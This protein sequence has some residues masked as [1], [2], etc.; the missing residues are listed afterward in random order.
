MWLY[1]DEEIKEIA[2]YVGFVYKI[3]NLTN[4]RMYIGKKLAFFAR[5]KQVKGKKKRY[6]VESD[7]RDYYGSNDELLKDVETLGKDNF[8]REI[9]KFCTS[10][11]ELSYYEARE[12]F[13]TDALLSEQYY[14][15]YIL[16]R[17]NS[18]H[19]RKK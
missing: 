4:G 14:N 3:T 13:I 5:F 12:Q 10:K 17:V 11:S 6:K 8:K 15:Q 19:L 9:I 7:W 18:K 16:L 2:P 1:K